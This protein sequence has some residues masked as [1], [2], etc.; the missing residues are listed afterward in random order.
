MVKY[1]LKTNRAK[2]LRTKGPADQPYYAAPSE[3]GNLASIDLLS[4]KDSVDNSVKL[5]FPVVVAIFFAIIHGSILWLSDALRNHILKILD[6]IIGYLRD[7]R[8]WICS[9]PS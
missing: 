2:N 1:F 8:D 9:L 6:E 5:P 4:H 7:L 3:E